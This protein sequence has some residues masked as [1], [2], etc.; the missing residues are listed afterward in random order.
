MLRLHRTS[1]PVPETLKGDAARKAEGKAL[2]FF[3]KEPD[4][5]ARERFE[6]ERDVYQ[7]ED[8]VQGLLELSGSKCAMCESR[9][10]SSRIEVE[11]FRP[12]REATGNPGSLPEGY[13]WLA[14]AWE[15]LLGLCRWCS[16][17]KGVYFPVLGERAGFWDA[18]RAPITGV[19][20]PWLREQVANESPLLLDPG[21]DDPAQSLRFT[22]DGRIHPLD[23]RGVATIDS[24]N[25]NRVDLVMERRRAARKTLELL[26]KAKSF[27][28]RHPLLR[29][30]QVNQPFAG[31]H[32]DLIAQ[33]I[34]RE[35]E[36]REWYER[37]SAEDHAIFEPYLVRMEKADQDE[38]LQRGDHDFLRS[39]F[40]RKVTIENF[41]G[42]KK[43]E[44]TIPETELGDQEREETSAGH[45]EHTARAGWKLLLGRTARARVPCC[46]RLLW[47]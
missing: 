45:H 17:V 23:D 12:V 44:F 34:A 3:R 7:A 25:L 13:W 39:A 15:N 47:C 42:I 1:V 41:K 4:R 30:A 40:L 2:R 9:I 8:V 31:M 46:K 27:T 37:L 18:E 38:H 32:R 43:V 6:F 14:Y 19:D 20:D 26:G 24:M 36:A 16:S 10:S 21:G 5:R 28:N 11:H 35:A 29:R 22:E 33:C